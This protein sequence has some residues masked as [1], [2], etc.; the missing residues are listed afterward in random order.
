M[1]VNSP[2]EFVGPF[3]HHDVVVNGWQVPFLTATPIPGGRVHLTLDNRM[4]IDLTV[5]EAETVVPFLADC[6]AVAMGFTAH[7]E[8][9]WTGPVERHPFNRMVSLG[10]TDTQPETD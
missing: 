9:D 8:P 10:W 4:G 3:E 1:L 6:M 5:Q 2:V 7:P